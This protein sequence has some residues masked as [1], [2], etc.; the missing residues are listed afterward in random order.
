MS[1]G[2]YSGSV[3]FTTETTKDVDVSSAISDARSAV[4]ALYDD[5]DQIAALSI[6][7]LSATTYRITSGI[8]IT[9]TYRLVV[10]GT[11]PVSV[12]PVTSQASFSPPTVSNLF[13]YSELRQKLL[14]DMDM[15]DETSVTPA[16]LIGYFN[17][18]IEEAESEVLKIDE[19]YFYMSAALPLVE[20][21]SVYPYPDNCYAYKVRGLVYSNGSTTYPIRRMPRLNK[22]SR[23]A[24]A[25]ITNNG[26]DYRYYHDNPV[27]GSPQLNLL[28]AAR[29]TAIM[30][31]NDSEFTPVKIHY[32]RHA[33]RIPLLGQYVKNWDVIVQGD[34]VDPAGNQFTVSGTYVA[35]DQVKLYTTGTM[36][37]SFTSGTVYYVSTASGTG[38]IKLAASRLI[39]MTGGYINFTS[40]GSG[41]LSISIAA[42]QAIIDATIVDLPEFSKFII[43]WAKCR[44]YEKRGDPRIAGAA[45]VLT[46]QRGQMVSTLTEMQPDDD[47][48]IQRDFSAYEEMS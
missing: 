29:E 6:V 3:V 17:E 12:A 20:G 8:P 40:S 35:G 21:E 15:L 23:I 25:S 13:L 14:V 7:A 48:E 46:Q 27:G 30:P 41:L 2:V 22:F 18:G 9:G 10:V 37:G 43:Q 11:S 28:P 47:S 5:T 4:P 26:D 19:D 31:P 42:N 39:A 44:C 45:E 32:I 24:E 34:A 38:Y 16:E 1:L 36:P 33:N